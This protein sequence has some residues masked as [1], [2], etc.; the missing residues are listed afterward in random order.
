MG[1]CIKKLIVILTIVGMLSGCG[2]MEKII[3]PDFPST[4]PAKPAKKDKMSD[5]GLATGAIIG[6]GAAAIY[7]L[8]PPIK[9]LLCLAY[10][11]TIKRS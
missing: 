8:V 7:V 6:L 5:I 11:K 2:V 10:N 9:E 3:N 4:T 1:M